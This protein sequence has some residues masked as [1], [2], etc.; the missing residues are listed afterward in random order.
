MDYL[1]SRAQ[2]RE[3]VLQ[4]TADDWRLARTPHSSSSD[5]DRSAGTISY[6][7]IDHPVLAAGDLSAAAPL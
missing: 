7:R 4:L 1:A 5:P 6:R 2:T 3:P